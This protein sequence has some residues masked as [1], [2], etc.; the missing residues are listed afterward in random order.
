MT[1]T[2]TLALTWIWRANVVIQP[3]PHRVSIVSAVAETW[4]DYHTGD[5]DSSI[6]PAVDWEPFF[7]PK[8][9]VSL[10]SLAISCEGEEEEEDEETHGGRNV[11]EGEA[12]IGDDNLVDWRDGPGISDVSAFVILSRWE[13][14]SIHSGTLKTHD[15]S[16]KTPTT[17][18]V[19][20]SRSFPDPEDST[21]IL[22]VEMLLG[23][24]ESYQES[25]YCS[26]TC[27][28]SDYAPYSSECGSLG[29]A[30]P[31]GIPGSS[32]GSL[33]LSSGPSTPRRCLSP[34]SLD[35]S[36]G[37]PGTSEPPSSPSL[38]ESGYST[39]SAFTLASPLPPFRFQKGKAAI[40][41]TAMRRTVSAPAAVGAPEPTP[42]L[43][44]LVRFALECPIPDCSE[45]FGENSLREFER[46]FQLKHSP[47]GARHMPCPCTDVHGRPHKVYLRTGDMGKHVWKRH[48]SVVGFVC[49]GCE[50]R[51]STGP[52][53]VEHI[54]RCS[55][56]TTKH[57]ASTTA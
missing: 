51:T 2:M 30:L 6:P 40:R 45:S 44:Q 23:P 31:F 29:P 10:D 20:P 46:H 5:L 33:W 7:P 16:G 54:S 14:D 39:S 3:L 32:L 48:L 1:R 55:A 35:N 38:S 27:T 57:R 12:V 42:L 28:P 47:S 17:E 13:D 9:L 11:D 56:L 24:G 34:D 52:D 8:V 37:F 21:D 22:D 19:F 36:W 15:P 26:G 49:R 41:A 25:S 50:K 43:H 53:I 4:S 18:S